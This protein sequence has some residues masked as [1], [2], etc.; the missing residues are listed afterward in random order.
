[1]LSF[2]SFLITENFPYSK[3]AAKLINFD[4]DLLYYTNILSYFVP[5][6]RNNTQTI[7]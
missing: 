3:I 6:E 4:I 7:K 1:M 2:S 5:I